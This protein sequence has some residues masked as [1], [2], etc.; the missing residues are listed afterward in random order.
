MKENMLGIL[1]VCPDILHDEW[2]SNKKK[3]VLKNP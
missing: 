1:S 2:K 3:L